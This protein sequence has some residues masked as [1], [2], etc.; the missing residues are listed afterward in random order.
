[1][2]GSLTDVNGGGGVIGPCSDGSSCR[3]S[4]YDEVDSGGTV[5]ETDGLPACEESVF[6]SDDRR[7]PTGDEHAELESDG[8]SSVDLGLVTIFSRWGS[9]ISALPEAPLWNVRLIASHSSFNCSASLNPSA[10]APGGRG[11]QPRRSSAA[12]S[13]SLRSLRAGR[14]PRSRRAASLLSLETKPFG[15]EGE[16]GSATRGER[17]N[18]EWLF[19]SSREVRGG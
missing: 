15:R 16:C 6:P 8:S 4:R 12:R 11:A 1:M 13:C 2:I 10:A 14:S 17:G 18:H 19:T 5:L 9:V 7:E 3:T